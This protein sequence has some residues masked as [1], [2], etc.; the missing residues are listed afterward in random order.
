MER[1]YRRVGGLISSR[2][3][4]GSLNA[5]TCPTINFTSHPRPELET[6]LG[7][8]HTAVKCLLPAAW[9]GR[10]GDMGHRICRHMLAL[11]QEVRPP[12]MAWAISR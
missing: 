3:Y 11:E 12:A 5:G 8:S 2:T 7:S 1:L 9:R 4:V 10:T 6:L